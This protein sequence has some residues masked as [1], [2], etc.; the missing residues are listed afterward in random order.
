M[1]L[2]NSQQ[3][4]K[5][6]SNADPP[7]PSSSSIYC[8]YF[9]ICQKTKMWK[10]VLVIGANS[11]IIKETFFFL[12]V[13][14]SMT[15]DLEM[16]SGIAASSGWLTTCYAWWAAGPSSAAFGIFLQ[17]PE[18]WGQITKVVGSHGSCSIQFKVWRVLNFTH[19]WF[20]QTGGGGC[21]TFCQPCK[22]SHS[23]TR[24]TS[25]SALVR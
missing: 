15:P 16:P 8:L 18:R 14:G 25:R 7:S 2:D 20:S 10:A 22:G 21:C 4:S 24:R 12:V 6:H 19:L 13:I 23:Q 5:V 17:C 9:S 1:K 11:I 3:Q